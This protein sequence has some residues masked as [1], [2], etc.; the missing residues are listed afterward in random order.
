MPKQSR[1]RFGSLQYWPRKRAKKAI[2]S[3]NWSPIKDL[4][5]LGFITYKVGMK[6][7]LVKDNTPNSMTKG[8]RISVPVTVLEAPPMKIFSARLYKN[9]LVKN[10]LILN[11]DKELKKKLKLPKQLKGL[12]ALEKED[13]DDLTILV[14]SL[15][16]VTSIKKTP[17]LIELGLGGNKEEKI[18]FVKDYSKKEILLAD[19]LKDSG[20]VDVRGLTKGK[21]LS[22]PMKRFGIGMKGHKSEKGRRLPGSLGPWHPARVTFRV[23]MAGKL[24]MFSLIVYNNKIIFI[25]R[26]SETDINPPQG[27]KH[28][29]KIKNEY[30][31]LRGSVQG[32]QKRQLLLTKP[33]RKT[34]K[35]EKK[36]F[37]FLELR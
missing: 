31:I 8:K 24:G 34:R 20:L 27:F 23:P 3:V 33:L 28:Y 16:K 22:G 19:V 14:Y 32:S 2:P 4:G 9:G 10:D 6:S 7:A 18:K 13:F 5:V 25:G 26:I 36:T 37:E 12:E 15:V 29:G 1:P 21:G 35:Q 11:N 17:D 30:L